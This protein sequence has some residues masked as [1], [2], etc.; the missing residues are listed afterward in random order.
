M[1]VLLFSLACSGKTAS[2][3]ANALD[4]TWKVTMLPAQL[5]GAAL[6]DGTIVV[7]GD[8]ATATFDYPDVGTKSG[9]CTIATHQSVTQVLIQGALA[10]TTTTETLTY[11]GCSQTAQAG[12]PQVL[13]FQQTTAQPATFTPYDGVWTVS[14][15]GMADVAQLTINNNQWSFAA[16]SPSQVVATG[17]V[18]NGMATATDTQS[19]FAAQRQ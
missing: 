17:S 12:S 14:V 19:D 13:T 8:T 16:T 9:P 15:S 18:L 1:V 2:T 4:G 3:S 10:T 5:F 6:K 11:S 7:S